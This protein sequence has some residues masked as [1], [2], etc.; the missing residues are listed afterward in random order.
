MDSVMEKYSAA[1]FFNHILI[2]LVCIVGIGMLD[3]D[4][5]RHIGWLLGLGSQSTFAAI[6]LIAVLLVIAL[7]CGMIIGMVYWGT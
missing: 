4:I 7:V 5:A 6:L 2:G 1:D 3:K